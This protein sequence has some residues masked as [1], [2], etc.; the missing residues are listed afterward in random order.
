MAPY[1]VRARTYTRKIGHSWTT[2]RRTQR[3]SAR[4]PTSENCYYCRC[5]YCADCK[6]FS[7]RARS[8]WEWHLHPNDEQHELLCRLRAERATAPRNNSVGFKNKSRR[9]ERERERKR[10]PDCPCPLRRGGSAGIS[11]CR[12]AEAGAA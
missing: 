1:E 4:A 6:Q 3:S 11:L 12:I 9:R 2:R 5:Y 7:P 8:P 10:G